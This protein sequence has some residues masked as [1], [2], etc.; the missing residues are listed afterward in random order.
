[1]L[2]LPI[3]VKDRSQVQANITAPAMWLKMDEGTGTTLTET[4]GILTLPTLTVDGSAPGWATPGWFNPNA[5]DDNFAKITDGSADSVFRLDSPSTGG[6]L[7]HLDL[8]KSAQ[9]G[10]TSLFGAGW[11]SGSST[12]GGYYLA[13]QGNG[14]LRLMFFMQ[15]GSAP[16]AIQ[17]ADAIAADSARNSVM[18]YID[19]SNLMAYIYVNGG[20]QVSFALPSSGGLPTSTALYG[21]TWFGKPTSTGADSFTPDTS[22]IKRFFALRTDQDIS[23]DL[24]DL[25][26]QFY[27]YENE[28]P[29]GLENY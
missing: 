5:A 25:A 8:K 17:I 22:S 12:Q 16:D 3:N 19:V 27:E 28:L 21:P 29:W 15:D 6:L 14:L 11:A 4:L 18:L 1:M 2:V 7:M 24:G 9:P 26:S 13:D 23:S 10:F 20:L